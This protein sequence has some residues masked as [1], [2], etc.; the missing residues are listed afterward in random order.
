M[1]AAGVELYSFADRRRRFW[2]ADGPES[3]GLS[4]S[5]GGG[6]RAL[7]HRCLDE[8]GEPTTE[9]RQAFGEALG[10]HRVAFAIEEARRHSTVI[11]PRDLPEDD[12]AEVSSPCGS[13]GLERTGDL[14]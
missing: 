4:A 3:S 1:T 10:T 5:H 6:D 12:P 11:D 9:G 7:V 2:A 13:S 8:I 14:K